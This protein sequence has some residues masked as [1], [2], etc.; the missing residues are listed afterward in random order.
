VSETAKQGPQGLAGEAIEVWEHAGL[1]CAIV[2]NRQ[3][4][5]FNGYVRLPEGDPRRSGKHDDLDMDVHG[6][7][8]YGPDPAGWVG[9]D[10]GHAGDYW[11]P[12]DLIG[13]LDESVLRYF[14]LG[15]VAG[16][17][18]AKL[19]GAGHHDPLANQWTIPRLRAEVEHLAEQLAADPR[20]PTTKE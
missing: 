5:M 15:G 4:G 8:T 18:Q 17:M 20:Q 3:I 19:R 9:F 10:T 13:Y 14:G 7:L 1:R 11:S 12:D 2:P 16:H 6:G